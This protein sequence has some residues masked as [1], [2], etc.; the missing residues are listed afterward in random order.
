M[1]PF[2]YKFVVS[3][4]F[5]LLFLRLSFLCVIQLIFFSLLGVSVCA[6]FLSS[7]ASFFSPRSLAPLSSGE[8]VS[9]RKTREER[10]R[11]AKEKPRKSFSSLSLA[12]SRAS[13]TRFSETRSNAP[14]AQTVLLAR[15]CIKGVAPY[16]AGI[17][18]VPELEPP[19]TEEEAEV[20]ATL[21]KRRNESLAL[22]LVDYNAA[23]IHRTLAKRGRRYGG[24]FSLLPS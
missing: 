21:R 23:A 12:R 6:C 24:V 5:S 1:D 14:C 8:I 4:F 10:G 13:R 19:N 11:K 3:F 2:R 15:S 22:S 17:C 18:L 20:S 16:T 9:G 7:G